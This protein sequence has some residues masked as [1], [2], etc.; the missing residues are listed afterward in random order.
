MPEEID[1]D[2]LDAYGDIVC[3]FC[4][5]TGYDRAGLKYHFIMG[6]CDVYN[7]TEDC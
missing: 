3:P 5:D 1:Y 6:Y 4:K 7:N 2:K